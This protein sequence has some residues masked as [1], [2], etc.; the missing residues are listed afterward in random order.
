MKHNYWLAWKLKHGLAAKGRPAP[1]RPVG[2]IAKFL[3][4]VYFEARQ[5]KRVETGATIFT[6]H[7]GGTLGPSGQTN[8][9]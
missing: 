2:I 8:G 9:E 7:V 4:Y 6:Q 1:Y 3:Y 5:P